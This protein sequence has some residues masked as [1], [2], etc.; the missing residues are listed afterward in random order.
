VQAFLALA[1]AY[2]NPA[3][4]TQVN[5]VWTYSITQDGVTMTI[6]STKQS[7]GAYRWL[8]KLNGVDASDGTVY[9]NWT[10]MEARSTADGKSGSVT[11]YDD[12]DAPGSA[13]DVS[14]TW[15][16][17]ANNMVTYDLQVPQEDVRL[18][19]KSNGTTGEV[20]E[21]MRASS[22]APWVTTGYHAT[23]SSVGG[24]PVC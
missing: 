3:F 13:V 1:N 10:A 16:T 14:F 15:S 7:D 21:Y 17:G 19:L 6:T 18:V 22:S 11:I 5:G 2:A 23:W 8:V 4:M 24:V 20:T 12:S 9:S